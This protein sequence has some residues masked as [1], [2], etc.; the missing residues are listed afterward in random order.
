M[1]VQCT[2]CK[3][4][5]RVERGRLGEEIGECRFNPPNVF[6]GPEFRADRNT[7]WPRTESHDW[8]GKFTP[9]PQSQP[10]KQ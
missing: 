8:C 7:L 9:R 1:K 2:N 3:Y 5:A 4:W 6:P 10:S